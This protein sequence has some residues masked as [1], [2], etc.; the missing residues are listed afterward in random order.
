MLSLLR[1]LRVFSSTFTLVNV[2]SIKSDFNRSDPNL[3]TLRLVL[4]LERVRKDVKVHG[5]CPRLFNLYGL[6]ITN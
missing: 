2:L 4:G 6:L 5:L 1:Y 3:E